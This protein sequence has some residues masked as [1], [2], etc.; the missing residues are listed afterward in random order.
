[1]YW[2]DLNTVLKE[3]YGTKVY[4]LSLS[5]GCSCPNREGGRG[6]CIFCDGAGAF[7]AAGDIPSQFRA[8]KTRVAA[9]AG[10]KA[11]YI[12]YFQ[13]FT[14]TYGDVEVL[15]PLFREAMAPEDIVALSIATRPDCLGEDVMAMLKRLSAVKP[16]WVELGLQTIH[17]ESA[18]YIRRGYDLSVFD[19]AV[20]KL[21]GIG[22][23]VIVHQILGLPGETAEMMAQ[24]ARYIGRSGATGVK[25]HLLHVLRG[26]DL[27]GD[28]EA[29]K[30]EVMTLEAYIAALE[31]CVRAV[32]RD[33]VIHR[34]TGDG[35][36]RDLI[37]PLWSGDKKRVLNAIRTAFREHD[38]EQGSLL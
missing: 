16:L 6:G 22:A 8:A 32:P 38:M 19:Q 28:Y 29:G 27:A 30:F 34:L 17:P 2:N 12:A 26:T 25:F 35:A 23:E 14:N 15:E 13:S 10:P 9:K 18:A 5:S 24:T 36:K 21:R 11:K 1:M 31:T 4:K 37:A 3:R 20:K 7:A 33:M